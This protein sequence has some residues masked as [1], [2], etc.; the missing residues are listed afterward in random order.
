MSL[1][2][3]KRKLSEY[4][5]KR[6][7]TDVDLSDVE[8]L[9]RNELYGPGIISGTYRGMVYTLHAVY[10]LYIPRAEVATVL[11]WLTL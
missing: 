8:K 1:S 3:L 7:K 11:R 6:N 2:M 4:I 10:G 9:I 5:L